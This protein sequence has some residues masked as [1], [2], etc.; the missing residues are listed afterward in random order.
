[1]A[2]DALAKEYPD[3]P[4]EKRFESLPVDELF[5]RNV[6]FCSRQHAP[7]SVIAQ[8]DCWAPNFLQRDLP[9]KGKQVMMLDFQLAR[10]A[11]PVPDISFLFYS[12]TDKELRDR[13]YEELLKI[14][15]D[16]LKVCISRLGSDPE[17]LYSWDVF[18]A[19]VSLEILQ[20][21][22]PCDEIGF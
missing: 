9:G 4:L 22:R 1:M 15:H 11:S 6:D 13:H 18:M 7:T 12:C 19:E 10:S 21:R 8:G 20:V 5:N 2:K 3:S 16:E 14:Y 17:K